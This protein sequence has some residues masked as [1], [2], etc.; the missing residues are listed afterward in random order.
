MNYLYKR[1]CF[2]VSMTT[3][4]CTVCYLAPLQ[5]LVREWG[6]HPSLE[7]PTP[8][9]VPYPPDVCKSTLQF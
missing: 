7:T 1:V 2:K 9:R 5:A 8:A 3:T 6:T 4:A